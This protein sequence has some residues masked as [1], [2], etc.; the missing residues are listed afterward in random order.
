MVEVIDVIHSIIE[1][2][3]HAVHFQL[4]KGHCL[5]A[6]VALTSIIIDDLSL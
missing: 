2:G 4:G 1:A 6:D 5:R 3:V